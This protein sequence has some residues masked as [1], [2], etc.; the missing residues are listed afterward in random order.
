MSA[1]GRPIRRKA[2]IICRSRPGSDFPDTGHLRTPV[3]ADSEAVSR[4]AAMPLRTGLLKPITTGEG[5]PTSSSGSNRA[6]RTFLGLA[7]DRFGFQVLLQPE[8]PAFPTD[9][10]L[11]EPTEGSKRIVT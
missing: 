4:Q 11:F 6:V 8:D 7:D 9:P 10:R 2:A 1:I 3:G 5:P